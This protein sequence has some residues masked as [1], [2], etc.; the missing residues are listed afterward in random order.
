MEVIN[1]LL[2]KRITGRKD[3][4]GRPGKASPERC[5]ARGARRF[6]EKIQK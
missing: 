2:C 1:R 3:L 6:D 4:R 5:Q